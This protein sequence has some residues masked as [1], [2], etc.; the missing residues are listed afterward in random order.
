MQAKKT[1]LAGFFIFS[2]FNS[3]KKSELVSPKTLS[4]L[5][6]TWH[7]KSSTMASTNPPPS[8]IFPG[9]YN[10]YVGTSTDSY[11]FDVN[12]LVFIS[13][14]NISSTL[15]Y[16]LANNTTMN[17]AQYNSFTWSSQDNPITIKVLTENLL[18]LSYPI[19]GT[20]TSNLGS[21]NYTGV[22]IDSL[23]K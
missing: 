1:I 20:Y 10:R 12:G 8:N 14:Y 17:Y 21:G 18:V 19:Y 3:C 7:L 23:T 6:N 16:S 4:L 2:L 13:M 15:K 9:I 22:R 11:T 5:Q